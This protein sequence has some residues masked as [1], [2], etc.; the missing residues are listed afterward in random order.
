MAAILIMQFLNDESHCRA[1]K[2]YLLGVVNTSAVQKY[3]LSSI[4]ITLIETCY[5]RYTET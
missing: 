2:I 4:Y 1:A 3:V 5:I